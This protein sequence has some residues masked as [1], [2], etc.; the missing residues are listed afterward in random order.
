MGN[1]PG[2]AQLGLGDVNARI[3]VRKA[4]PSTGMSVA[5]PYLLGEMDWGLIALII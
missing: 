5:G 1:T 4:K 3:W 2:F